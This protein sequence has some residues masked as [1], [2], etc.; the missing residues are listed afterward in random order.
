MSFRRPLNPCSFALVIFVLYTAGC[1]TGDELPATG[2]FPSTEGDAS[3]GDS[4]SNDATPDAKA[5]SGSDGGTDAAVPGKCTEDDDCSGA[6]PIC[7][8][9]TGKCV[10]CLPD[11]DNCGPGSY[12]NESNTC[13]VGCAEDKDCAS[14]GGATLVCDEN[15]HQCVGCSEAPDCPAGSICEQGACV[16]GCTEEHACADGL[17][18][19]DG[20]CFDTT[21]DPEH[22]GG[23]QAC[24]AP[25]SAHASPVCS[26]SVC[27]FGLCEPGYGDCNNDPA[28]GCEADLQGQSECPCVP[29][30]Q[31]N[32]YE[33]PA[34]TLGQ[35]PCAPG[36]KT[37]NDDGLGYGPCEGQVL[38]QPETC[39][40]DVDDDCN[41]LVNDNGSD[42]VCAPNSTQDCYTGPA[43][44]MN[45]GTCRAGTQTCDPLGQSWG[46]CE[47]EV[48]PGTE[49]C[50]LPGDE[51]CDG[52]VNEAAAGC[53]CEPGAVQ[54]CY[55]GPAGT[56]GVGPCAAGH[57]TCNADG[58]GWGSCVG[59]VLPQPETCA[60]PIDDDCDGQINED[61]AGCV[62]VPNAQEH[63][64]SG[65]PGTENV[66]ICSGGTK[67]CNALGTAWGPCVGEVLPQPETCET[68]VDDNCNGQVNESGTGC[69]CLPASQASC[70]TGPAG[71]LNIGVCRGGTMTCNDQGTA[72]GPCVGQVLPQPETCTTPQ[73]DDCDGQINES[74]TGC[75][76][77]PNAQVECYSGPAGTLN[78]GNCAAGIKTCNALGTAWSAC[79]GEVT[80]QPET[81]TSP[82]D[83]DCD[84]Q[85]NESGTGCV[86][87]PNATA[88][89]YTGPAGTQNVGICV[90]GTKKCNDV[91]TAWGPCEGQVVPHFDYCSTAEDEDCNGANLTC[92]SSLDCDPIKGQCVN[93]CAPEVLGTSYLGC[94]YYPTVTSNS[95]LD[96]GFSFAVAI[97]NTKNVAI[98]YTITRGS[99]SIASGT[100]AANSVATVTLPWISALVSPS[101]T[102]VSTNAQGGGAY[103]L[104]TDRPVTVYQ[105]NPLEYT[106]SSGY[107]Y[108]NDASLLLPVNAWTGN[109]IV[110]ARNS[111]SGYPGFYAVTASQDGTVVTLQPSA[112]GRVVRAGAGVA[113]NGTGT[114]TLNRGDVLQVLSNNA[115]GS[116]DAADLTGTII[117]A[118]KPVQVIGGH[119]C[120]NI[121]YNITA[122]DH[123]EEALFPIETL[124]K[125]YL[126]TA[127]WVR[128]NQLKNQLVRVIA[129]QPSTTLTFDPP[130]SGF[131]TA[132]TNAGQYVELPQSQASFQVTANQKV[133][134]VQYMLGQS[135]GGNTGDPAM[136]QAV[137]M[138]QYRLDYLFHAPTNYELNFVNVTAP[139]GA[140]VLLDGTAIT[141]FAAIGSTGFSVARVQLPNTNGGNHRI[142]STLPAG[143]SVYGYGQ[144][145]SYWY[146]GG[147]DLNFIPQ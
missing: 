16:P 22:C 89:C 8:T 61:G 125:S 106:N 140:T 105:Y 62:C 103:R 57:Q 97:S 68:P 21:S 67:T 17:S 29:G 36:L 111:W 98:H 110:A 25:A 74:G 39:G 112:T 115:G 6:T 69:T 145:T 28:D 116:P 33:G 85:I 137:A 3:A 37:C 134:V 101:T 34:S 53:T 131:P 5:D 141:G 76:C 104:V 52:N 133:M 71:T 23:C 126:V 11:R 138:E 10:G 118:T 82:W 63:C 75:V 95:L 64:Y 102:A 90:G 79:E 41:G 88:A 91:G 86:C 12:C 124:S 70:Y 60:T 49:D 80:P 99:T 121:P 72:W 139:T 73:D 56:E 100:V 113:T 15:T 35:G 38:P 94:E 127:P 7:N 31:A 9:A 93:P 44:T 122:C 66:G 42:C 65:P 117:T 143:I 13:V 119:D 92:P 132:I 24:P 135:A 46:P 120:T 77:P 146:P 81:C 40:N 19:C 58:L 108:T 84:G 59:Q 83:E 2:A 45:V 50:S 123:I 51:N 96:S 18:C 107:T 43:E 54:D 128:A 27:G 130:Q 55:G 20:Q 114:I 147:L 4:G 48:L 30:S 109:Y 129:T 47:G 87:T 136:A 1:G 142:D 32:C 26:N 14:D 144:Y 78:V